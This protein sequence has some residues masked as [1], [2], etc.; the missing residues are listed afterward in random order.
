MTIK[1]RDNGVI[2]RD[3]KFLVGGTIV[4]ANGNKIIVEKASKLYEVELIPIVYRVEG[5]V[6]VDRAELDPTL[7]YATVTFTEDDIEY[8]ELDIE[9][10]IR[11][12]VRSEKAKTVGVN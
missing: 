4:D 12:I 7:G 3:L 5:S 9:I 11:E 10:R 2:A 1:L 8:A 6:S